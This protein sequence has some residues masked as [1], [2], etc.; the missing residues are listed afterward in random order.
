M[1]DQRNDARGQV[2]DQPDAT[3][4]AAKVQFLSCPA[5]YDPPADGIVI[6]ETHMSWVFM[7]A[8]RVYKLKKP[9]RF[10]YLDFST[11]ALRAQACRAEYT[12]NRRLAPEVYLG[13]V[14]LTYSNS[15][16]AINGAGPIVDWLVVMRRLDE[17]ATLE[18]ALGGRRTSR[19][20]IDRLASILAA[21][22]ARADRI[23][24]SF[25]E[26]PDFA[27]KRLR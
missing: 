16:F 26:L 22:Y 1:R 9:V 15:G 6:R 7:T 17:T 2:V 19:A 10:S 4:I 14:P 8:D 23:R 27:A 11:L 3:T 24:V 20:Q 5:S 18:A 25:G 13:F 21:F 12:L